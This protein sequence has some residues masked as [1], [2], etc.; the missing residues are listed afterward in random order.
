MTGKSDID[1]LIDKQKQL[2]AYVPHELKPGAATRMAVG[3][4][5]M[6]A[7]LRY[8]NSTAHKPWRPIP[9]P[10]EEQDKIMDEL[11][12]RVTLLNSL[13]DFGFSEGTLEGRGE[14][15]NRQMV[16]TFGIIEE[17]IEYFNAV[18]EGEESSKL[19][20]LTDIVFFFLEQ[21]ILSGFTIEQIINQYHKKWKVNMARYDAAKAGD[22]RWDD[23]KKGK[24]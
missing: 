13:K 3:I 23:R 16:S 11:L 8:L 15:F 9:L 21:V 12:D 19:E 18:V 2:M 22:Y 10:K 24:L 14:H 7:L 20:E 17:S 6:D 1:I 4:K 5:I